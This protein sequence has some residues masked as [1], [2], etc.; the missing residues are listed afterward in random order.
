ME[1]QNTNSNKIYIDKRVE[2][3]FRKFKE[4]DHIIYLYGLANNIFGTWICNQDHLDLKNFLL[5]LPSGTK[6]NGILQIYNDN[7]YED[8][9][10]VLASQVQKL[11]SMKEKYLVSDK[12][13]G[14]V[15]KDVLYLDDFDSI[16][17]EKNVRIDDD[18]END[19]EVEFIDLS[20]KIYSEFYFLQSNISI[21]INSDSKCDIEVNS[22]G[23]NLI[24]ILSKNSPLQNFYLF[25]KEEKLL[26]DNLE[27]TNINF[28]TELL[29]KLTLDKKELKNQIT[30]NF[31]LGFKNKEGEMQ[32]L[33]S[34]SVKN[35]KIGN[36]S[37]ILDFGL[38]L[39]KS[40]S[41]EKETDVFK[42]LIESLDV[43]LKI[44][45][46]NISNNKF[47]QRIS[48]N[49]K[50]FYPFTLYAL[51]YI[52][53][54]LLNSETILKTMNIFTT[55]FISGQEL[56]YPM[57]RLSNIH[58]NINR[59]IPQYSK[60]F[61]V[62]GDYEYYHYSQD[63]EN[64]KG[65]GCAYRSLQTLFSWF[66]VNGLGHKGVK[67]PSISEIQKTLVTVGD[68]EPKFVGSSDWIGAFEVSIILNELLGVESQIIYV[69]SGADL[70]SKGR[71]L[72][73]HFE[74]NGSPVMIG[75]GVYAYTIL[76]VEY[77]RVKGECLFL[78]LD[79]HYAGEDD[80]KTIINKGWCE[81][82]TSSLF[83]KESFYNMCLPLIPK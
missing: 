54:K 31:T 44:I 26:I 37:L 39:R 42:H 6:I 15:M 49:N 73:Y 25:V 70:T 64:D 78:I 55:K 38:F 34:I 72:A 19:V 30:S 45:F 43:S 66:L 3:T 75:G 22:L 32:N 83:E 48:S 18:G 28:L 62:K 13:Y 60:R 27:N 57:T 81:W 20:S 11:K 52:D 33:T 5:S 9:D 76:G 65:W 59:S 23:E 8:F 10:S 36:S 47:I 24:T 12:L 50:I 79:P 58:Q 68:K 7:V 53:G 14:L 74:T 46:D 69:S 82:K 16:S 40:T 71:E 80:V 56:V 67:V 1:S 4:R 77:D 61:T 41:N 2:Q 29:S 63:S 17:F 35:N 51:K 21:L